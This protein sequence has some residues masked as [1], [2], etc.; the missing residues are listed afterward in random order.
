MPI[1]QYTDRSGAGLAKIAGRL[2]SEKLAKLALD[3]HF[4]L[5]G[6]TRDKAE[7]PVT[8]P[9]DVFL[10]RLYFEGQRE[11]I[12][13]DEADRIDK[14]LSLYETLH[15]VPNKIVF[16]KEAS[17]EAEI[18]NLLPECNVASKEEL[19]QAGRDFSQNFEKLSSED[20]RVFAKNFVK[21][22][23]ALEVEC[24]D[25]VKLYAGIDVVPREDMT[26]LVNFRKLAMLRYTRNDGG[27]G[28]LCDNLK[29]IDIASLEQDQ[30]EK[31]AEVIDLADNQFEL[32]ERGAGRTIPDAW[33]T[34]F[35]VK[36]AEEKE[37]Q[38][39]ES[40][41]MSRADIIARFGEG[42]LEEIEDDNGQLDRDRLAVL[43]K[44]SNAE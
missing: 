11:K 16:K 26:S 19:F 41:T 25:A 13:A 8:T 23:E 18:H 27:F 32:R 14:R 29:N 4:S 15:N 33:H 12:A 9:K 17:K 7:F 24:P 30:L 5:K 2:Q 43:L 10:S 28:E 3:T 38:F 21:A 36:K 20:R 6:E 42:I 37:P 34:V 22:A 35:M 31:I 39:P 40:E 44:G 1:D